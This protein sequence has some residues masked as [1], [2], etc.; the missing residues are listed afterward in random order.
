MTERSSIDPSQV[1]AQLERITNHELFSQAHRQARFLEH[2][3]IA[4]LEARGSLVNQYA[5]AVEVFDRDPSFDPLEDSIV[6]VEARPPS[7]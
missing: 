4:E 5:I 6:R 3:V 2:V 1:K 7:R